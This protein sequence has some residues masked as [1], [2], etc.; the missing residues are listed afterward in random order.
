M[1]A[2]DKG[3]VDAIAT[4]NLSTSYD[5]MPIISIGFSDYYFAVSK[6]RPDLL[7]ELN[8]ALYEIQNTEVD[9]NNLLVSRYQKKMSNSLLL[10]EKEEDWLAD[11][12]NIIKI[13]YLNDNLPYSV[14][15]EDGEMRG[16]MRTLADT[17]EQEFKITVEAQCY[18]TSKQLNF[19]LEQGE[20]DAIG[21]VYSDFY[22]AEQRNYVLTNSFLSTTPVIIFKT[23]DSKTYSDVIAVSNESLFPED[24]VHI[25]Y[26]DAEVY[27][28]DGIEESLE[29][30]A[31]GKADSTLVTSIRLNVLRQYHVMDELQ[32]ADT[33]VQSEICLAT[34]KEN[35]VSAG[36]LN[37]GIIL[38][39]DTLNGVALAENSYVEKTITFGDFI[40]AHMTAVF[41]G[42]GIVILFLG[43]MIYQLFV[44]GKKLSAALKEAER[45]KEYAYK[46]YLNNNELKV[47]ANQDA[48][49]NIGNRHFF[50]T[51]MEEMLAQNEKFVF[52]Y[53]DL[54]NLKYINDK[55]GHTEGDCYIRHF[56]DIVKGHIRAEDIFARIGGDEFCIILRRCKHEIALKKIQQMQTL[57]SSDHTKGYPKSF[58]CG[59]IEVPEE[60]DEIEVMEI[61]KQADE[62]MYEQK[63]EHKKKKC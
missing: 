42:I 7:K 28:C 51:K 61:L 17:L 5:Y 9:Y 52:C 56:V 63:K 57:F 25:L 1:A 13:G 54:D 22:L 35:R 43:I 58:S 6:R 46:L 62:L 3:E 32:F 11:H 23:P 45:E 10:E 40:K 18:E 29:A 55:Y 60:H 53:C 37:K 31:S 19:A 4:P 30:V 24:V 39:S 38:A 44:N 49:T 59:I 26:P 8:A 33:A 2:L 41:G 36:I 48:L 27:L 34:T 14:Q 20:V 21:P 47:K 16:V 15:A 12:D 50:F